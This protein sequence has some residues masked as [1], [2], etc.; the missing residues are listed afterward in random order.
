MFQSLF[1]YVKA[2]RQS[3]EH[4]HS[5]LQRRHSRKRAMRLEPLED[6][7]LLTVFDLVA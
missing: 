2:D 6:R 4:L 1:Q 3:S 7:K 5:G